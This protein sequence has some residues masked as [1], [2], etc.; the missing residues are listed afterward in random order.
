MPAYEKVPCEHCGEVVS[1]HPMSQKK[2]KRECKMSPVV[3]QNTVVEKKVEQTVVE[4]PQ[5]KKFT[6]ESGKELYAIAMKA[7]ETRKKSPELFVAGVHSDERKELVKRYAPECIEPPFNPRSGRP[8]QFAEWHAFF[9]DPN[10]AHIRAHR[11]YE[12]VPNEHGDQVQHEGD[13]LFRI[14]RDMWKNTKVAASVESAS[15]RKS[16][17]D[18]KLNS[19]ANEA[20][21]GISVSRE[22]TEESI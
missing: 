1:M 15:R 6:S 13:L 9:A 12:P 3:E 5:E 21:E 8:R 2:H 10:K 7:R 17:S 11:G 19:L 4:K 22:R 16:S 18:G 20:V 14:P